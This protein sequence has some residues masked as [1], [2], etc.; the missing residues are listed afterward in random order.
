MAK[1]RLKSK[2]HIDQEKV[3]L[4]KDA[5]RIVN[6][7]TLEEFKEMLRRAGIDPES[8]RGRELIDRLI[9]LGASGRSPR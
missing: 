7:G 5:A 1:V 2:L 3:Q 4:E 6:S 9:S 8:V